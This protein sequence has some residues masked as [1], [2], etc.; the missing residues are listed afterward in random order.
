MALNS[1]ESLSPSNTMDP[2]IDS[3][4]KLHRAQQLDRAQVAHLAARI[5]DLI[6]QNRNLE[7]RIAYL[8]STLPTAH[9]AAPNPPPPSANALQLPAAIDSLMA[10][11]D[12]YRCKGVLMPWPFGVVCGP[13]PYDSGPVI[14]GLHGRAGVAHRLRAGVLGVAV[15]GR[16][17]YLAH[18]GTWD[19]RAPDRST[20]H[21]LVTAAP[22]PAPTPVPSPVAVSTQTWTPAPPVPVGHN[23]YSPERYRNKD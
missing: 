21:E 10:A 4:R 5:N 12:V 14:D 23:Q 11:Q 6:E 15:L 1:T 2:Q 8:R 13:P 9:Q 3:E 7:A 17:L 22:A 20:R 18:D 19:L 16:A